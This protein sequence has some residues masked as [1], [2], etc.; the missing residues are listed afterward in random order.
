MPRRRSP[1][2]RK[3]TMRG[4]ANK[5]KKL[6]QRP[7]NQILEEKFSDTLENPSINNLNSAATKITKIKT[8]KGSKNDK[9]AGRTKG[10]FLKGKL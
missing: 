9:L 7:K 2:F 3:Q 8:N 10:R 1:N 5:Y 4:V 6:Q